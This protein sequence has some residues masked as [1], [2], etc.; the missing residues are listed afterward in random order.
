MPNVFVR[1][2]DRSW[3]VISFLATNA[4]VLIAKVIQMY[5][6]DRLHKSIWAIRMNAGP[7]IMFSRMEAQWN[8]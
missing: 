2:G 7:H 4:V 3:S 5:Y 1:E 6:E 8:E